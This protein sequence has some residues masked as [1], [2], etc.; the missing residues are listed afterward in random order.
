MK[1]MRKMKKMKKTE[2]E[3]TEKERTLATK[4]YLGVW[5]IRSDSYMTQNDE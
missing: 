4:I 1:M 2:K 3:L 5:N